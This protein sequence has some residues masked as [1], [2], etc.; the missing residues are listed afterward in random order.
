MKKSIFFYLIFFLV[1]IIITGGIISG[2]YFFYQ[3]KV[4]PFQSRINQDKTTKEEECGRLTNVIIDGTFD[5]IENNLLYFQPKGEELIKAIKITSQ[6]EF[7]EMVLYKETESKGERIESQK[8]IEST[9]LKKGDPISII[10]LCDINDCS[11][12]NL[13]GKIA[14]VVRRM[15]VRQKVIK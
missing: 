13:E 11:I 10:A 14:S 5:K 15:V 9:D 2:Y 12:N 4:Q 3:K 8:D 7:W 1:S 6:T